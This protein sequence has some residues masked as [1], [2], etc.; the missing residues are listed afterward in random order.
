MAPFDTAK[1]FDEPRDSNRPS[2]GDLRKARRTLRT[3]KKTAQLSAAPLVPRNEAQAEF[4][5][6]L[7]ENTTVIATGPAGTGK[8]YLTTRFGVNLLL[9]GEIDQIVITRP[10]VAVS[11]EQIGFL[12]GD[13]NEKMAPWMIPIFD[14]LKEAL[15]AAQVEKLAQEERIIVAPFQFIRGR[16]FNRAYIIA[17][18]AQNLTVEQFKA[19]VTRVGEESRIVIDGDLAQSDLRGANGLK[20]AISMIEKYDIDAEIFEFSSDDIVRSGIVRQWVKAFE[21]EAEE[22]AG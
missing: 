15:P 4:L 17:D 20:Y 2:K 1:F 18:E 22:Q 21:Q 6:C 3:A 9:K 8:S 19:L 14:A 16:T 12:P 7:T 5:E 11:N 13:Q 10:L